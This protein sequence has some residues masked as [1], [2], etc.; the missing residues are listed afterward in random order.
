MPSILL[1]ASITQHDPVGIL[2][3]YERAGIRSDEPRD[4]ALARW[5][6]QPQTAQKSW[7]QGLTA[8]ENY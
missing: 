6:A 4:P 5:A 7:E 8:N 1:D 2:D 3:D